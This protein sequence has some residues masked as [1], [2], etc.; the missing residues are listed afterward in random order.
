MLTAGEIKA[1]RLLMLSGSEVYSINEIAKRIGVS[2]NGAYK[3]LKKFHNEGILTAQSLANIKS[4]RLNLSGMK[5]K[6]LLGLALMENNKIPRVKGREEDMIS[7]KDYAEAAILFGSYIEESKRPSDLDILFVLNS[8]GYK[9]F[10]HEYSRIKE[11]FPTKIHEILQTKEDL[12]ENI[13]KKDAVIL[14]A[15]NKGIV[16]WGHDLILEVVLS[17]YL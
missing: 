17:A 10:M 15:L 2:P 1:L 4:Y 16:L 13:K 3:L 7:L 11:I 6:H 8:D 14:D 12:I 5:T 9:K